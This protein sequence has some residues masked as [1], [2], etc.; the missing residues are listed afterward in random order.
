LASK[1]IKFREK[2]R[3]IRAI[4]LF[5]V[6]QAHPGWYEYKARIRLPISD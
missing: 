1:A 3:K 2:K 4:M 5:K 6:I